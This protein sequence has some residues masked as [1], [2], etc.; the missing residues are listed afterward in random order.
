MSPELIYIELKSG[1]ADDGP[2]WIGKG[3]F[4]RTRRTLYFNGRIFKKKPGDGA[5][6]V[7]IKTGEG[8]WVTGV[9]KN[10]KDRNATGSGKIAVDE[11]VLKEYLQIRNWGSLTNDYT[12][13]KLDNSPPVDDSI[14]Q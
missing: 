7:D 12:I 4:T 9:R 13:V 8:H 1:F 11:S 10:G 14:D 5:N 3:L 6:Y 2:A